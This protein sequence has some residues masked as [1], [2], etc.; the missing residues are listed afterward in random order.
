MYRAHI[1]QIPKDPDV[2]FHVFFLCLKSD[3]KI[4]KFIRSKHEDIES[5]LA[6][7]NVNYTEITTTSGKKEVYSKFDFQKKNHPLFYV[8]NRHPL[9]YKKN[10]S[11]LIMEWGN[12]DNIEN[13]Q[14]DLMKFVNFFSDEEFR[15]AISKAKDKK[16]WNKISTFLKNHGYS[17]FS[18][19]LSLL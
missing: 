5:I 12:W 10:D 4:E 2:D 13:L 7:Q 16:S 9:S 1:N 17:I 19:G 3:T 14:N 18:I 15:E 6:E 11:L 8:L